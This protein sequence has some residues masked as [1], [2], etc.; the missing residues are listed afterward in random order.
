M[1]EV[2]TGYTLMHRMQVDS[3]VNCLKFW[4]NGEALISG[5]DDQVVRYWDLTTGVCVQSIRDRA[6]GQVTAIDI[7]EDGQPS[8]PRPAILFIGTGRGIVSIMS[9]S[10]RIP[11]FD[12]QSKLNITL[13]DSPV[14]SQA[15]DIINKRFAVSSRT[16]IIRIYTIQN[17]ISLSPQPIWSLAVDDIPRSVL[18]YGA[19][20]SQLVIHSLYTSAVMCHDAVTGEHISTRHLAGGIG[21]AVFSPDHR[22]MVIHNLLEDDIDIYSPVNSPKPTL[23]LG[24]N[25][26][27]GYP[28]QCAFGEDRA[29]VLVCGDLHGSLHVFDAVSGKHLQTLEHEAAFGRIQVVTTFSSSTTYLIASG[30]AVP[31]SAS[32]CLWSKSIRTKRGRDR[33]D[34]Q[35]PITLRRQSSPTTALPTMVA[36]SLEAKAT[37]MFWKFIF[38]ILI[39]ACK[40]KI[41]TALWVGWRVVADFIKE[42]L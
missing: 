2:E 23:T 8:A 40:D 21:S 9:M 41:G 36:G 39:W 16:G 26:Y 7:I 19:N 28:K 4:Q 15:I 24:L 20:N 37:D 5:D 42:R 34:P 30:E 10:R 22:S 32:I 1:S 14:E 25:D 35:V 13:F 27:L 31:S 11:E 12:V 18:F 6:W 29:R 3:S 33:E 17:S 38:L